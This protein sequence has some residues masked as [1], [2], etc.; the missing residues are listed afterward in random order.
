M[1]LSCVPR[2]DLDRPSLADRIKAFKNSLSPRADD[3]ATLRRTQET[4]NSIDDIVSLLRAR[5][6]ES[7]VPEPPAEDISSIL[8][9]LRSKNSD[10]SLS[11][12]E[13]RPPPEEPP[14]IQD[15]VRRLTE[16]EDDDSPEKI[17]ARIKNRLDIPSTKRSASIVGGNTV[18]I[19]SIKPPSL[20]CCGVGTSE[21]VRNHQLVK[22]DSFCFQSS[23][24]PKMTTSQIPDLVL[25]PHQQ[26]YIAAEGSKIRSEILRRIKL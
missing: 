5:A 11:V 9:E 26:P 12:P 16:N 10:V 8:E 2:L 20:N 15:L 25:L 22:L 4:Y 6:V 23:S 3:S 14:N 19:D 21:T 24:S 7:V 13:R 1:S 18:V 17:I